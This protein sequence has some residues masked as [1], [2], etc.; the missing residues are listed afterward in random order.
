MKHDF[1]DH[2]RVGSSLIHRIDPRAKLLIMLIYF[3]TVIILP[4][5][6]KISYIFIGI[7][8]AFLA[9]L[10]QVNFWHYLTKLLKMYPMIFFL[11]VFIPFFPTG[12]DV[13]YRLGII[14]IYSKG[15]EKFLYMNVKTVIIMLMTV[16][17]TST[18]DFSMLLKGMEKLKMPRLTIAVLSFMYRFIFLFIDE[19]ERMSFAF[20]SRYIHLPCRTRFRIHIKQ[21]GTFFIKTYERGERIYQSM[22][23]RG[24]RGEIYTIN[25]LHWTLQDSFLVATF[26]L[27]LVFAF[28]I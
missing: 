6:L 23:S 15:L 13:S 19:I 22:E 3:A 24:F 25:D 21:F 16:V 11:F 2:H 8:P 4:M 14:K 10:S 5:K 27:F 20:Q 17:L 28:V 9:L 1:I 7:L 12:Q 18:T 26:I